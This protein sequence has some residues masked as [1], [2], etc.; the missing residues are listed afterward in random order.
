[1]RLPNA[2]RAVV[3]AASIR[4]HLVSLEHPAGRAK[5]RFFLAFGFTREDWSALQRALLDLA[6]TGEAF[7]G[8]TWLVRPSDD[9]PY[10]ITAFPR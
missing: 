1:M 8:A 7:P 2:D 6:Q 4:D 3:D 9:R 10:F 5:G